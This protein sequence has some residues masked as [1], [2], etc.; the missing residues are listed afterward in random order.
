MRTDLFLQIGAS[1]AVCWLKLFF[2]AFFHF[3]QSFSIKFGKKKK[4]AKKKLKIQ[5]NSESTRV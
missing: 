3:F 2:L 4:K 1:H 5:I